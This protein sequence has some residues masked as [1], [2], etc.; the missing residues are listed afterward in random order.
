MNK[1]TKEE[2][3]ELNEI[4]EGTQKCLHLEDQAYHCLDNSFNSTPLP[5][6][7]NVVSDGSLVQWSSP[8]PD[9]FVPCGQTTER[10][11]PGLYSIEFSQDLGLYFRKINSKTEGLIKFPHTQCDTI[12]DEIK[13]FW[14]LE[15]EFKKYN[16]AHKRGQILWG[17]PGS[18]KTCILQLVSEDVIERGGIVI[19]FD[20]PDIFVRGFR[21]LRQIQPD[22]PVVVT[23]ED[24]DSL[25]AMY[26]EAEIINILDGAE[27]FDKVI[28]MAT[29]NYP[30]LLGK[31]IV[32]RPSRFDKRYKIGSPTFE[33]RQIYFRHLAGDLA[34]ID[35]NKYAE[36]TEGL[37][38]AHLKEL[39]VS[40]II[41]GNDYDE[42][43]ETLKTM[44]LDISSSSS[45]S[46]DDIG[47]RSR[48]KT[49]R[50]SGIKP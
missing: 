5:T 42:T 21:A 29:T 36:D 1:Q 23:M 26:S 8:A 35:I 32:N 7:T 13:R 49:Q 4:L 18:G 37:S 45:Y 14:T 9:M 17:E 28:F 30:E 16:L 2:N 12:V 43:L 6:T 40:V 48:R 33:S 24:I 31:R 47:L 3:D 44:K 19:K 34:D 27:R 11:V 22:T 46:E 15:H 25:L 20:N 50:N 38:I 41:L 39:F 10:L